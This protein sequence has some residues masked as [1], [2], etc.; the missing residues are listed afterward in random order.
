MEN[1]EI[2]FMSTSTDI[3][4]GEATDKCMDAIQAIGQAI[5]VLEN[6]IAQ[7]I[8]GIEIIKMTLTR[9]EPGRFAS[10]TIIKKTE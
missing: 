10:D 1:A 7:E 8:P 5:A 2:V 6:Q 9:I 3:A 4:V